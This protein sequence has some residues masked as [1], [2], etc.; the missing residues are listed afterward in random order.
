MDDLKSKDSFAIKLELNQMCI[1]TWLRID[2]YTAA[3][4]VPSGWI[5]YRWDEEAQEYYPQGTFVPITS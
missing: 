4:R 5:F 3:L 2:N 1:T